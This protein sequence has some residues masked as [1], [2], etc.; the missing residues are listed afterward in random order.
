MQIRRHVLLSTELVECSDVTDI[1]R[2]GKIYSLSK[3]RG[4]AVGIIE[5]RKYYISNRLNS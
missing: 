4:N 1:D 5:I 2:L 3:Y